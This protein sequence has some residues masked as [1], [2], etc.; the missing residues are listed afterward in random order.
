MSER[1]DVR[2]KVCEAPSICGSDGLCPS[3]AAT[4]L[5]EKEKKV[6]QLVA[7]PLLAALHLMVGMVRPESETELE[8]VTQAQD[9]IARATRQGVK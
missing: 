5:T 3:C 4:Y 1:N 6:A 7:G 2:A 9:A 8:C